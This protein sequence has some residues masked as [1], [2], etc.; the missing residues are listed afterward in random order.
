[1]STLAF[2]GVSVRH[3]RRAT[4]RYAVDDVDL[5][6]ASRTVHGLIGESGS[7]KS[8]LA[9]AA[10]GLIRPARGTVTLDGTDL[11]GRSATARRARRRVQLIF[12]DPSSALDPRMT[13]GASIAEAFRATGR[14]PPPAERR[15]RVAEVLDRVHID[16]SRA[17]DLPAAFSGG[18]RQ[19]ITIARALAADPDVLI[20]DEITSSLDV[21][22]QGVILN[23]LRE[24]IAELRLT[25]LFIS[26]NIAVVRYMCD[27]VSVMR[28]GRIVESGAAGSLLASPREQYTRELLAAVP[29]L[30]DRPDWDA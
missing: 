17:G 29:V 7:G 5:V 18:Q 15:R 4:D 2:S 3:G 23:V 20:A 21:S 12:Q 19:R 30:G 16:P 9:A 1:M 26:H 8:S 6:V 11:T 28:H 10:V 24:V 27:T 25:V 14:L 22:V 13:V